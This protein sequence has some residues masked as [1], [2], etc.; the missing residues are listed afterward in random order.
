M[1]AGVARG[2][3]AQEC[4]EQMCECV[5]IQVH[6]NTQPILHIQNHILW[7]ENTVVTFELKLHYF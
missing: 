2:G 3:N 5:C 1:M 6:A 4:R 7:Y